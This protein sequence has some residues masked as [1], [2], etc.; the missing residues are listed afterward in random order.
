L[1]KLHKEGRLP[2]IALGRLWAFF[3]FYKYFYEE[4]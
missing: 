3:F 1:E 4:L 2:K